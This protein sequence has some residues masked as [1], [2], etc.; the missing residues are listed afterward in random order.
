MRVW[1]NSRHFFYFIAH[2]SSFSRVVRDLFLM[3]RSSCR[4][5]YFSPGRASVLLFFTRSRFEPR[6]IVMNHNFK[7]KP[8]ETSVTNDAGCLIM[9]WTREEEPGERMWKKQNR[10]RRESLFIPLLLLARSLSCYLVPTMSDN[11]AALASN[12]FLSLSFFLH[13]LFVFFP[14]FN[15]RGA[16]REWIVGELSQSPRVRVRL[17]RRGR[18]SAGHQSLVR[19]SVCQS[20]PPF[21]LSSLWKVFN[22]YANLSFPSRHL[23]LWSPPYYIVRLTKGY[24]CVCKDVK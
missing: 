7:L 13:L 6:C 9:G 21:F 20:A 2:L 17:L 22:I 10:S 14:I 8:G 18:Q 16:C 23:P 19:T 12:L 15:A 11:S 3:F 1:K 24:S 5:S 4:V